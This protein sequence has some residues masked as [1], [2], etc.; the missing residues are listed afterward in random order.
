MGNAKPPIVSKTTAT[1]VAF[2][3]APPLIG[4]GQRHEP[5][6]MKFLLLVL[7]RRRICDVAEMHVFR[8]NARL[9]MSEF[10]SGK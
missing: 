8:I 10:R 3:L 2:M 4:T 5:Y 9:K 7:G 1:I 6:L